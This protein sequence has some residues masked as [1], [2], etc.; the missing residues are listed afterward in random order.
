VINGEPGSAMAERA[1]AI[2][3][4]LG[5][6]FAITL[7]YRGAGRLRATARM[8]SAI[9]SVRPD[10]CYVF[11]MAA[12]GVAAAGLYEHATGAPFIVDTGDVIVDLARVLGRRRLGILATRALEAYSLRR[13]GQIIV[14]GTHHADLLAERGIAAEFVPDGVDVEQ[15][16][17]SS[18]PVREPT[19]PLVIGLVGSS[20]SVPSR[21]G[22]Y[23]WELVELVRLL[24]GRLP[25]VVKGILIGDGTGVPVLRKRANECG[26]IDQIV[27]AGRMQYS[28][29]PKRI[30]AFDIALTTQTNDVIGNV[31]TTGKL[32]L[33]LAAGRFVLASRVGE[34][35]RIL[36][37]EMLVD[38]AGSADPGYP[39]KLADRVC[40]LLARGTDFSFRP[41]CVRLAREHFDYDKLAPRVEWVLNRA[42]ECAK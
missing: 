10:A 34:A 36:P 8:L 14:R 38:F 23:G 22:C 33:Y 35:A 13:A 25:R 26:V 4:R 27:F 28:E 24:R 3:A 11:D 40:D 39:A 20:V 17:P 9:R 2:A 32:P 30:Q 18:Q 1:A 41:E 21:Q 37:P 31:R 15:F 16:V 19:A 7:I 29:L 12:S 42:L 6:R 5:G